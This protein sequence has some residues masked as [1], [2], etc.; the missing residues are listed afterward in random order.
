MPLILI[1][2]GASAFYA[3][4]KVHL[5]RYA[6]GLVA[7]L[8][9]PSSSASSPA[10]PSGLPGEPPQGSFGGSFFEFYPH[11]FDGMYGL[12][13]NF[14]WMGLHLWYLEILFILSLLCLPLF[15][16]FKTRA[17]GHARLEKS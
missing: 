2:S 15:A 9:C 16:W 7:R 12:G 4:G 8:W 13:G 1:I 10:A 6:L 3:L 11:Y 5:G 14:V 17:L